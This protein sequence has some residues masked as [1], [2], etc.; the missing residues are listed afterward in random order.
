MSEHLA[1]LIEELV[2]EA[3]TEDTALKELRLAIHDRYID[4]DIRESE[5]G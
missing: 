1:D 5:G 3:I 4:L 2:T